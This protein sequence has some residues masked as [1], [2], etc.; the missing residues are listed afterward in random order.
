[1]KFVDKILTTEE[2]QKEGDKQY[3]HLKTNTWIAYHW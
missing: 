3:L 2:K 1:M